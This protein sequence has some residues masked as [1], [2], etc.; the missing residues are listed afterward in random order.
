MKM[1]SDERKK[2]LLAR[3][4]ACTGEID[5]ICKEL[6]LG[7]WTSYARIKEIIASF[8]LGHRIS[9]KFSGADA[10]NE[11]KEEVEYKSTTG[12]NCKGSYTGIS[13]QSTWSAMDNYLIEE[14][15]LKYPEHYFN[16]FDNSKLVES[17]MM[18]GQQVYDF[19]VPKVKR[20]YETRHR[21]KD[22]RSSGNVT[23]AE[24][25]NNGTQIIKNGKRIK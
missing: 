14:K 8:A 5:E 6:N 13:N 9:D 11:R 21:R 18:T 22:S 1:V 7:D 12:K 15:I 24:I 20:S 17:W 10:I 4:Y 19:I 3:L 25:K 16:R 2:Y 23:W